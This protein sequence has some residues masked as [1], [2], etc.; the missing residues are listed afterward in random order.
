MIVT[1]NL[2]FGEWPVRR[3]PSGS[4]RWRHDGRPPDRW[5]RAGSLFGDAKMTT[6]LL[7]RLTHHCARHRARTNGASM[8]RRRDRQRELAFQAPR[9]TT[10]HPPDAQRGC[11]PTASPPARRC[12]DS[13]VQ[14]TKQGGPSWTPIRGPVSMLIDSGV[15]SLAPSGRKPAAPPSSRICNSEVA[16]APAD[17]VRTPAQRACASPRAL[18]VSIC[19]HCYFWLRR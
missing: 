11:R 8:A 18:P 16:G 10:P 1:T 7:D 14:H 2:A 12:S 13:R 6:A 15:Q 5:R 9:L 3:R 4:N 19:V 17:M